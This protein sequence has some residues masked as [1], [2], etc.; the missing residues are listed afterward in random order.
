MRS[1][2]RSRG[3]RTTDAFLGDG[4]LRPC[5]TLERLLAAIGGLAAGPEGTVELMAHPGHAPQVARTSFGPEREVELRALCSPV[6]REA[7]ERAGI[8]LGTWRG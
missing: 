3:I 8:V 2:L 6:A 4:S 1:A 7:I 5:W